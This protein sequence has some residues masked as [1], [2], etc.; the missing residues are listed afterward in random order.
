[1]SNPK[2]T[3]TMRSLVEAANSINLGG[4]AKP[5]RNLMDTMRKRVERLEGVGTIDVYRGGHYVRA[6]FKATDFYHSCTIAAVAKDNGWEF[7]LDIPQ[8]AAYANDLPKLRKYLAFL[9]K[10][11][12][13]VEAIAKD[14][15]GTNI[16]DWD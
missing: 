16:T 4:K 15:Q 12:K 1:M 8:S 11:H 2:D 5:R 14:L 6:D 7:Q 10:Y 3:K 9:T 13:V